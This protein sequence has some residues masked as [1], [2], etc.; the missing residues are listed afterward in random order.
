[1][2]VIED[3]GT[4]Y[5]DSFPDGKRFRKSSGESGIFSICSRIFGKNR[6]KSHDFGMVGFIKQLVDECAMDDITKPGLGI[7]GV[8]SS[9]IDFM[10]IYS[11]IIFIRK[12]G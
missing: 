12:K 1:M 7:T 5:W 9:S 2:Y 4:G 11:G 8:R 6:F 10:E 3:W